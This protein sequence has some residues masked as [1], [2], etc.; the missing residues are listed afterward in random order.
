MPSLTFPKREFWSKELCRKEE[1][2]WESE[3]RAEDRAGLHSYL[4]QAIG[5]RKHSLSL[6]PLLQPPLSSFPVTALL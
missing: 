2:S 6:F 3:M 4:P 5:G 1:G